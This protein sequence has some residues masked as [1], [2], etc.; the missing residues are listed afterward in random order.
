MAL[1]TAG[2]FDAGF[3]A[4]LT[5]N[6][7]VQY[8]DTLANQPIVIACARSLLGVIENEFAITTEWFTTPF[9]AP[10]AKF[11]PS[12]RQDVNVNLPDT[13]TTGGVS[14]P[15]AFNSG[16]GNAINLDSQNLA[17]DGAANAAERVKMVFMNEWV[18]ILMSLSG[19]R[20]NARTSGGEGLSQYCGILRF[21]T[22]HYLYYQSFVNS[23]LASTR[24]ET[25]LIADELTDKN[26][27]SFGCAL[28]FLFYLDTQL[29]FSTS[30]I[31]QADGQTLFEKYRELTGDTT[32]LVLFK[33]TLEKT[34]PGTSIITTGN[35]DNPFPL[36]SGRFLS[37]GRYIAAL[38]FD[39]HTNSVAAI[40]RQSGKASL[41]PALNSNRHAALV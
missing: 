11:G 5:T 23:W 34:F 3:G 15:G 13:V 29:G 6:F 30:D 21:P 32:D 40:I 31:I 28:L 7:R 33:Q 41:R 36:P 25:F 37:V 10:G 14:F 24:D 12:N 2:L 17:N 39:Q 27:V 26:A 19:G 38:P 16:F 9:N 22:G 4:G 1:T 35:L 8:D 18:E 20:W